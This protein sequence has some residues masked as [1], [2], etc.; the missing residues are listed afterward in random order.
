M[1]VATKSNP[2]KKQI[3]DIVLDV[4]WARFSQK[5]FGKSA[6]WIY[7]KLNGIDGNGGAGGLTQSEKERFKGALYDFAERVR[8]AADEIK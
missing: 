1:K 8:L 4:S 7:N 6:S 3:E 5:Y 2:V